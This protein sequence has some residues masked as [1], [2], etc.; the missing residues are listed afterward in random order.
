MT[1][2]SELRS[3]DCNAC[4][5][6]HRAVCAQCDA[7]ELDQLTAIKTYR[8]YSAGAQIMQRGAAVD[9]VASVVTGVI[10]LSKTVEDGRK[11][12]VGRQPI[13]FIY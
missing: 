9:F 5:I 2:M 8:S 10:S 13:F 7:A 6:C 1:H 3:I 4:P 12:T 11:Q